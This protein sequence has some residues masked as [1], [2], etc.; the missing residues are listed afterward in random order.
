VIFSKFQRDYVYF[1]QF[2]NSLSMI[3]SR[4]VS[5]CFLSVIPH[6]S[7]VFHGFFGP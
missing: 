5:V 6:F 3:I 7:K 2:F 1:P 4:I